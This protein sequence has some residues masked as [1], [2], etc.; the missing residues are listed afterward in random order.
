MDNQACA[1]Y[2]SACAFVSGLCRGIE[3]D[4]KLSRQTYCEQKLGNEKNLYRS[5]G[6]SNSY[7]SFAANLAGS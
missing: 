5:Q 2:V 3:A 6:E 7:S 1:R 4:R